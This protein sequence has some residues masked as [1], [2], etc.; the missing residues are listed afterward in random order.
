MP[1]HFAIC[2]LLQ[3]IYNINLPS[4]SLFVQNYGAFFDLVGAGITGPV[5]LSGT[6]GALDLSSAEWTYQVA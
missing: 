1:L 5:K 4:P 3:Q 6:N 2:D